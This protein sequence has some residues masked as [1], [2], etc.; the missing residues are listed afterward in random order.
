MGIEKKFVEEGLKRSQMNEYFNRAT[1]A[2]RL[3]RYGDQSHSYGNAHH[4]L[5]RET[6]YDH[7]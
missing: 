3:R 2:R 5:C 7:W 4:Y 6:W 1:G